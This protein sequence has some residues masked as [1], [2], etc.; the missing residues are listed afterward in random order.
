MIFSFA[1]LILGGLLVNW[2]FEK[3]NIP[4]L[5]GMILLGIILGPYAFD[6]FDESLLQISA[7]LRELALIIIL[8][9]AS[10]GLDWEMVKKRA[11]NIFAL[12]TLPGI[13]EGI[14]IAFL[15]TVFLDFTFVQGGILGFIIAA[16]SPAVV[17]P[18]MLGFISR[19]KGQK[20]GIPTMML[21]GASLDDVFAITVFSIFLNIYM[22]S[23]INVA[24]N[25]I[26]IPISIILAIIV[27]AALG[28]L[29]IVFFKKFRVR[30]TKKV[31]V[32]IGISILLKGFEDQFGG[33]IPF[34]SLLAIMTMGFVILKDYNILAKRLSVKF[35]KI[36]VMAEIML[37]VLVG[38]KVNINVMFDSGS[39]G[40]II[41]ALGLIG[42]SIGV[43]ISLSGTKFNSME[44]TFCIVS[45]IPKATVQ[46]AIG[47]I[48]LMMG[49]DGGEIIL[50]ISVL[51]IIVTAPLGSFGIRYLGEKVLEMEEI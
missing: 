51:A 27:G 24:V 46:A 9:R 31:L 23:N 5:I 2:L 34:R 38:A 3:F 25:I 7:D 22:F 43:Y 48:P 8:L 33:K 26:Q 10:L 17:V 20:K 36:W 49:V 21:A 29:F 42:R 39:I 13:F 47:S 50:A 40:L 32:S 14:L 1:L 30:D 45:Y 6:V 11:K 19:K 15:A 16:V 18:S 12:S 44:K 35:N 37:F 41:I 28:K 4:G